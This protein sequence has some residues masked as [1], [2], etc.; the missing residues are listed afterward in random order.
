MLEAAGLLFLTD[1][2]RDVTTFLGVLS[3][4]CGRSSYGFL[5]ANVFLHDRPLN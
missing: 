2:S 5:P 1:L 3:V 4:R